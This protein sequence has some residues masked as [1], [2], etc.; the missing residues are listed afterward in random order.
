MI[1][2]IIIFASLCAI[3][4]NSL[5]TQINQDHV[6]HQ[7]RLTLL[8]GAWT[9]NPGGLALDFGLAQASNSPLILKEN[10]QSNP[11]ETSSQTRWIHLGI[12]G[13]VFWPL[14]LG[15]HFSAENQSLSH[16]LGGWVQYSVLQKPKLPNLA[17]RGK[18]TESNFANFAEIRS[19]S[20]ELVTSY[21]IGPIAFLATGEL[22]YSKLS[23]SDQEQF[24]NQR[25]ISHHST[26]GISAQSSFLSKLMIGKSFSSSGESSLISQISFE[27]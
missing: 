10:D 16:Q 1:P 7:S 6:V 11:A 21:G 24:G 19:G 4:S 3:S 25:I 9:V 26:L 22:S 2:R 13:G 27:I 5:G 8:N 17:V 12:A 18:F 15:V 14:T 20:F 23:S